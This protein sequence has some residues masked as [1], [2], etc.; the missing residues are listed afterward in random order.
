MLT[1]TLYH[2]IRFFF[3]GWARGGFGLSGLGLG[4]WAVGVGGCCCSNLSSW[5]GTWWWA[6]LLVGWSGLRCLFWGCWL[7][8]LKCPGRVS[9]L[10]A[11]AAVSRGSARVGPEKAGEPGSSFF[12][13]FL[14]ALSLS[15]IG[16]ARDSESERPPRVSLFNSD[17][18]S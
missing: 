17:P 16:L 5:P 13:F 15:L 9:L 11:G 4:W 14:S 3:L 2:Q 12:L 18:S 1:T 7:L 10:R 6:G 8:F